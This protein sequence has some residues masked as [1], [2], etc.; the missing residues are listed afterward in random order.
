MKNL[1]IM[2]AV[3]FGSIA[4]NNSS[5]KN[6]N[7]ET[8]IQVPVSNNVIIKELNKQEFL[9]KVYNFEKNPQEWVYE[10]SLPCIVDFY[11]DWCGPCKALSPRLEKMA[12]EFEGMI[13]IYKINVDKEQELARAFG[14]SSIPALLWCPLKDEPH[15]T[16]GALSE[17]E[18]KKR[19]NEELLK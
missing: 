7:S 1:F 8:I 4:C 19:I 6:G 12:K 9:N 14:I 17:D 5:A 16:Q 10:G 11:A 3:L 13:V 2:L 15:F 18:L